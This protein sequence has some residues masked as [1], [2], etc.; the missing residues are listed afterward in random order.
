MA[1]GELRVGGRG[2]RGA[3]LGPTVVAAQLFRRAGGAAAVARQVR[4]AQRTGRAARG[5]WRRSRGQR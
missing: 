4:A 3:A 1:G 5:R 2:G